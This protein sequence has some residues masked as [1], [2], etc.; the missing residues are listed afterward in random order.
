M[1]KTLVLILLVQS[2]LYWHLFGMLDEIRPTTHSDV[3][4]DAVRWKVSLEVSDEVK[5]LLRAA[6][7]K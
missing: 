4:N 6:K 3:S 7:E 2:V 1:K 5:E